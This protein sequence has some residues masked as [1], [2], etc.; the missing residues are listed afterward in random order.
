MARGACRWGFL[1]HERSRSEAGGRFGLARHLHPVD[2]RTGHDANLSQGDDNTMRSLFSG[3]LVLGM[4]I[5]PGCSPRDMSPEPDPY[6]GQPQGGAPYQPDPNVQAP[7]PSMPEGSL[8]RD[9]PQGDQPPGGAAEP[10]PLPGTPSPA[11]PNLPGSDEP[12]GAPS[13]K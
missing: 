1:G 8:Q 11:V 9:V 13:T 10:A 4:A 5:A 2:E 3:V 7:P 6:S 12:R